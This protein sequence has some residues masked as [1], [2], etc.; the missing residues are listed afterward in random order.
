MTN[1]ED[2]VS[3]LGEWLLALEPRVV[4]RMFNSTTF[5][6][7]YTWTRVWEEEGVVEKPIFFSRDGNAHRWSVTANV[8]LA[9]WLSLVATYFGRSEKS[10]TDKTIV[11]HDMKAVMGLCNYLTVLNFGQVLAEGSPEQVRN[12]E[13][14]IEAY[15][16]EDDVST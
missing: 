5:F 13:K 15:L 14:V 1:S 11:E 6:G 16:G 4:W 9:K 2:K 3:S 10:F 7:R 12:N 8:Q